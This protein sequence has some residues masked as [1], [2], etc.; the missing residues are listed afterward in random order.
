MLAAVESGRQ[1]GVGQMPLIME[2]PLLRLARWILLVVLLSVIQ[3]YA[4]GDETALWEALRSGNHL[5]LLRHAVAPGTGDPSDFQIGD[6]T[7]QRNLS[8]AGRAQSERIG[9][10]FRANAI[11]RAQVLSSQWCRCVETAK[12]L[13]LGPV[14]ELPLLNSFFRS[15]ERREPKT[16]QLRQWISERDLSQPLVLV[17]H[18]V[19]ITALTD[20][21]PQS[22]ELVIIRR[23]EVGE[24]S[25]VGTIRT[26]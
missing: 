8:D 20:V 26:D 6:C 17:T 24:L 15:D 4:A 25:V 13:G 23:D 9:A 2:V 14:R 10:R 22:G 7:T 3:A 16:R 19:N 5:A 12:L 11:E 21:Y 18:Q 1:Q